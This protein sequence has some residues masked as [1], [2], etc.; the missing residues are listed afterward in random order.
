MTLQSY[1]QLNTELTLGPRYYQGTLDY[2]LW[3]PYLD[4]LA[5]DFVAPEHG[6]YWL[7]RDEQ[8]YFYGRFEGLDPSQTYY[9]HFKGQSIPDPLSRYQPEGIHGPSQVVELKEDPSDKASGLA[10]TDYIIYELHVGTFTDE[11]T[12]DAVIPYLDELKALGVTAIELMPVAQFPGHRNWGYDGALLFAAQ[13]SYGGPWALKRLVKACHHRGLAVVL[14]VVY[15]HFG[16]EGNYLAQLGG[17]FNDRHL[18][19]WGPAINF[20]G[21]DNEHV[22]RLM[23]E[24]ALMWYS[25]YGIDALRLDALHAI[26]DDS[27]YSFLKE[28]AHNVDAFRRQSARHIYLIGESDLNDPKLIRDWTHHGD[29]LDGQWNDDFHHAL[30]TLLTGEN[31]GY[32]MDFGEV[33]QLRKAMDEGF[34][35]SGQ[36]SPFRGREHGQSSADLAPSKF[37]VFAQNHDQVGNRSFGERL[38]QLTDFEALKLAAGI[39]LLS[40]NVPLIFMGE[41]YGETAPFLY[42]VDHSSDE[43]NN[44]VHQ[45]RQEEFAAFNWHG[46]IP[47]PA[48]ITTFGKSK[49]NHHLKDRQ[50]HKALYQYYQKLIELRKHHSVLG[51]SDD[52]QYQTRAFEESRVLWHWRS[53]HAHEALILANFSS[54]RQTIELPVIDA[55]LNKLIDS[56]DSQWSGKDALPTQSLERQQKL[57]LPVYHF[58][59]FV[60]SGSQE[61]LS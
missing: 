42:F 3:A 46:A 22:R 17:Y 51:V 29:G 23:I 21:P 5:I 25:C 13:N 41:E 57:T 30:H 27:D 50:P 43:L 8:G 56:G 6:R 12:F 58:S 55:P 15:N 28:L 31:Q 24:N 60:S 16:P 52:H 45:G 32:Y 9:L 2:R 1:E 7:S 19:P 38:S 47:V 54:E 61:A 40:P 36:Y 18:T 20:D 44:A 59:V 48:D 34:V 4:E 39:V 33:G 53:Q 49:L 37:V 14:D 10:L 35:Y 11:G 26:Y